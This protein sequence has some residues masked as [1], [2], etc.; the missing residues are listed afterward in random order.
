MPEIF[1][2]I[3]DIFL[4]LDK[5]LAMVIS[6]YG[7]A[8]YGF[9]FLIIFMETGFVITPFLPGDS[10]LFAA[11]ALAAS[12]SLNIFALYILLLFASI[13]GDTIN[14][15]VGHFIGPK[16]FEGEHK[17][18]KKEYLIRTQKFYDKYGGQAITIGRFVPIVR[19]FVPFVAGIAKMSY[20]F[21]IIYNILGGVL[22]VSLFTWTGY[23]FGNLPFVKNNFRYVVVVIILISIT[24]IVYEFLK[25][26][27][28]K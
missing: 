7:V 6:Q 9:L 13:L 12:S 1:K 19:T 8:T 17:F 22:W 24:P 28:R 2:T 21:F 16:V 15:W 11:G 3:I 23:F 14:Y 26:K 20:K 5:N 4:H 10:L 25:S 18:I 27:I